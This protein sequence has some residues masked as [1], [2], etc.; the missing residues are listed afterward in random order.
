[1]VI[2]ANVEKLF[3]VLDESATLYYE[4]L[5]IPYLDGLVKACENI[6]AN[7]VETKSSELNNDL[8]EKI[9]RIKDIEFNREEIR[10]AFQYAC[11][12][13]LK[14]QNI[15]NQMITPESVSIFISYLVEKL[16]D[17]KDFIIFDPLV[18]SG[19]LITGLANNL[20]GGE[21]TLIGV[22]REMMY[23]KLSQALFGMLE[24]GE[25]IFYQDVLTFNNILADLIVTDFS[26]VN[27]QDIYK[28]IKHVNS[29]LRDDAFFISV[30]DN[31]FFDDHLIKDFI[32]EVKDIWHFFGMIVLP[33]TIFKNNH[34]SIFILQKIGKNFIRPEKFLVADLPDFNNEMEMTKVINQ[35][36]DWFE[37]IEFYIVREN[38]EKNNGS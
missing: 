7:S 26:G 36:N 31:E 33:M 13:G 22:D 17:L 25:A 34:K 3:D 11:L 35:I 15:S 16:Y 23:Y 8:Q 18:G 38:D 1:M 29:L 28:I 10:K 14:H 19:N 30:I 37:K 27:Q 9:N 4:K 20:S 12:K 6:I 21:I 32:Y 24:Y 2:E 5:K